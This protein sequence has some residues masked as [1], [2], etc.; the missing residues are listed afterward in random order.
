ELT[1]DMQKY[2]TLKAKSTAA[3]AVSKGNGVSENHLNTSSK[4]SSAM[5]GARA[6]VTATVLRDVNQGAATPT[7]TLCSRV[8]FKEECKVNESNVKKEGGKETKIDIFFCVLEL[9]I[10][11]RK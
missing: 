3:E 2:E 4:V 1:Y 10:K 9:N 7:L 11:E 8:F 5:A 6:E